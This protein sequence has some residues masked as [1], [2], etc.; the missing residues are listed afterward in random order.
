VAG[1]IGVTEAS[2]LENLRHGS[3][4]SRALD[5]I[6]ACGSVARFTTAVREF[7]AKDLDVVRQVAADLDVDFGAHSVLSD[8]EEAHHEGSR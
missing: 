3:G 5:G 4:A 2:L 8:P 7:I 1:E 6:A